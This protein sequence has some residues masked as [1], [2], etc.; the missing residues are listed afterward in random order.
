MSIQSPVNT[1]KKNNSLKIDFNAC[2]LNKS[3]AINKYQMPNTEKLTDLVVQQLDNPNKRLGLR[4]FQCN[5]RM[6]KDHWTK[7]RLNSAI[8]K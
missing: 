4:L 6:V 7:P 8:S 1:V 2:E 3:I 5:T